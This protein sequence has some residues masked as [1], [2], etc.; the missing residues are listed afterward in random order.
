MDLSIVIP[1]YNVEKYIESCLNS[2]SCLEDVRYEVI[3]VNDGSTDLTAKK[4]EEIRESCSFPMIVCEQE[5]KGTAAARNRGMQF[6]KGEFLFFLD[7]DD[8]V[9]AKNL[10]NLVKAARK[11]NVDLA[12]ADYCK[13]IKG[14]RVVP[15]TVLRRS[16]ILKKKQGI[17]SGVR[18]A[19][20]TFDRFTNYISSEMAFCLVKRDFI[21]KNVLTF[22]PK[23][24]HEDTLFFHDCIVKATRV[25]YYD[26]LFY[27]YNIH[28]DSKERDIK[29]EAVRMRDKLKLAEEIMHIRERVSRQYYFLDSY[30]INLLYTARKYSTKKPYSAVYKKCCKFT[31]KSKLIRLLLKLEGYL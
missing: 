4:I 28:E 25:K 29:K 14:K 15:G 24:Y 3:V 9:Y 21:E 31:M 22:N 18:F 23:I 30:I 6:A 7:A 5:N 12:F 1:C 16:K 8:R 10:R 20:L 13:S 27:E 2:V 26:E 11:D 17:L 19:E